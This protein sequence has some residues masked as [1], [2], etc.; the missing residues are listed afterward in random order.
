MLL[1]LDNTT[2]SD[3]SGHG[4]IAVVTVRPFAR[5]GGPPLSLFRIAPLQDPS[6][7]FHDRFWM[8]GVFALQIGLNRCPSSMWVIW[9]DVDLHLLRHTRKF[10]KHPSID[11]HVIAE[12]VEPA[13]LDI[14]PGVWKA[15]LDVPVR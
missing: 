3:R 13:G 6:H 14:R 11:N 9:E 8:G 2:T 1:F 12:R 15:M 4:T 7:T 10:G 5:P